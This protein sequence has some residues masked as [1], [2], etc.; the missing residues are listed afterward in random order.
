MMTDEELMA[1]Q[2]RAEAATPGPWVLHDSVAL[3]DGR[4]QIGRIGPPHSPEGF[5]ASQPPGYGIECTTA[6]ADFV[7][8][9]RE[10]VLALL[11]EVERLRIENADLREIAASVAV[12]QRPVFPVVGR[13]GKIGE[14]WACP[15]GC[16]VQ[17]VDYDPNFRHWRHGPDC[18][19]PKARILLGMGKAKGD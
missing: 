10:D 2:D 17:P 15:F 19:R 3:G 16:S 12:M 5:H 13:D 7:V 8:A 4:E 6:D 18:A 14:E 9:A 1:I 11:A